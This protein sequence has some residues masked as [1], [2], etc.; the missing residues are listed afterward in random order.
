MLLHEVIHHSQIYLFLNN[1]ATEILFIDRSTNFPA[2]SRKGKNSYPKSNASRSSPLC[3]TPNSF[4][5]PLCTLDV[6]TPYR[7]CEFFFQSLAF[8]YT[9]MGN[10]IP[11]TILEPPLALNN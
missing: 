10:K 8:F 6:K 9:F 11:T 3:P 1:F 5:G 7:M 4:H 2:L